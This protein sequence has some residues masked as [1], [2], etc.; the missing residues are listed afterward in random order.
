MD[1]PDKT[2]ENRSEVERNENGQ[3]TPGNSGN[4]NGRPKGS[5]SLVKILKDKLEQCPEGEDKETYAQKLVDR[6]VEIALNKFDKDSIRALLDII[7]RVDG[8]PMQSV[9]LTNRTLEEVFEDLEDQY[10]ER[11]LE[12]A[13][14]QMVENEPPLQDQG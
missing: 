13:Q 12:K 3:F 9:A 4:P 8:K 7:D 6:L 11:D 2:G 1:E 10:D 5:I 14:Q